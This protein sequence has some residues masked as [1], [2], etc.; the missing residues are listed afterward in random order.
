MT[1]YEVAFLTVSVNAL[2]VVNRAV[3]VFF[4]TDMTI[5]FRLPYVDD[6]SGLWIVSLRAIRRRYLKCVRVRVFCPCVRVWVC[7]CL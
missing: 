6:A 1:P 5:N 2:F 3:D 4:L 7:V